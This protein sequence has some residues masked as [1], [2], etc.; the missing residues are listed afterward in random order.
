MEAIGCKIPGKSCSK[1]DTL[2]LLLPGTIPVFIA[3]VFLSDIRECCKMGGKSARW[4][5]IKKA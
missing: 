5:V 4:P 1:M 2:A 3:G